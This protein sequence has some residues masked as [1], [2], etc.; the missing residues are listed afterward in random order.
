[1]KNNYPIRYALVPMYEYCWRLGE[2]EE[3]IVA[4]IVT[5][6]YLV[7]ETKK[8]ER[9]GN[10]ELR[11]HVVC[12][13]QYLD[14]DIWHRVEPKFNMNR[15][16][17]NGFITDKVYTSLEKAID[18]KNK[19]NADIVA[20]KC[21]H[22]RIDENFEQN[23][24]N[25]KNEYAEKFAYYDE[26]ESKINS[27][28]EELDLNNKFKEQTVIMC[29]DGE[30]K[31]YKSSLYDVMDIY[32]NDDFIVYSVDEE[33]YKDIQKF[34]KKGKVISGMDYNPILVNDGDSQTINMVAEEVDGVENYNIIMYTIETRQD[35][36]DSYKIYDDDINK[37]K[38]LRK[39]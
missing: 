16:C 1:M 22:I 17:C 38:I 21:C 14:F 3:E 39:K 13:Y 8:Y 15:N 4:Y 24:K 7:N 35:I 25:I 37:I 34:M 26:V 10:V 27:N 6:C 12:P 2:K 20:N 18:A 29:K 5:K 32:D 31:K 33:E 23:V 28:T 36:V 30:Y 11:Y 19:K 9:N